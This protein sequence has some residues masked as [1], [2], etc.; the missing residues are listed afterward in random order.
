MKSFLSIIFLLTIF[1]FVIPSKSF[2]GVSCQPIYGGGQTCVTIGNA[3]INKKIFNPSTSVFV[4]NLGVNDPKYQPDYIVNFKLEVTNNGNTNIA[5]VDVKDIFPQ[6]VE[7]LSGPGNFDQKT[8]TLTFTMENLAPNE[9]RVFLVIGKVVA[10]NQ[11]PNNQNLICVVNQAVA[12][13][14]EGAIS[15]DNSQFCIERKVTVTTKGGFP[16]LPPVP[17]YTSPSTGPEALALFSLI[18]AGLAGFALRKFS[19]KMRKE[20][21]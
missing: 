14:V 5:R 13:T 16:V 17:V 15:Q 10:I 3:V 9:T 12:T 18:P 2:A 1:S 6:Y 11:F 21:I 19:L 4:D 7:W 20:Q 8:K